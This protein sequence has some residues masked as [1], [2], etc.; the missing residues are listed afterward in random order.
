MKSQTEQIKEI[1]GDKAGTFQC[2]GCIQKGKNKVNLVLWPGKLCQ[3]CYQLAKKMF[4]NPV[5][6]K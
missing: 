6:H 2:Y 5:Y 3:P 1:Y 4:D